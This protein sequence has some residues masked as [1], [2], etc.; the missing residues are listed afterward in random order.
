MPR[1][2]AIFASGEGTTAEAITRYFASHTEN[3]IRV[4]LIASNKPSAPVLNRAA[5]LSVPTYV[6]N[7]REL[8]DGSVAKELQDRHIGLV[9]LGGFLSIIPDS[10][11]HDYS[12]RILNTHPSLL[13]LHGGVGMYGRAVYEAIQREANAELIYKS[14]VTIHEVVPGD[15]DGGPIVA[16]FEYSVEPEMAI[17]AMMDQVHA[18]EHLEYPRIIEAFVRNEL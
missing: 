2:I 11:F 1:N 12:G 14:G 3:D 7:T 4:S 15:V 16:Q 17:E 9:A 8:A 13:P 10:F 5:K 6:F 18:I